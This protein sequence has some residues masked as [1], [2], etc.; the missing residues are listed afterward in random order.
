MV[1]T[2]LQA[3]VKTRITPNTRRISIVVSKRKAEAPAVVMALDTMGQP[4]FCIVR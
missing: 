2:R 3:R 4:I 1:M